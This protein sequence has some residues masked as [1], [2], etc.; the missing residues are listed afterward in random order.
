MQLI[1]GE[2]N[3]NPKSHILDPYAFGAQTF[4]CYQINVL[5]PQFNNSW[6]HDP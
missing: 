1:N 6:L 5:E 2:G 4:I 3:F